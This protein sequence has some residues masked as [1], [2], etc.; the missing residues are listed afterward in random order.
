MDAPPG[1]IDGRIP[2]ATVTGCLRDSRSGPVVELGL[3]GLD[4]LFRLRVLLVG[5]RE[6][7]LQGA[8]Y[9]R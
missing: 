9:S 1:R 5:L 2:A 6:Q 3:A 8:S 4:T 7:A